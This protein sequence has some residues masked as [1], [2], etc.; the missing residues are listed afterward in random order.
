ML[1]LL[2]RLGNERYAL[3]ASQMV[4]VLPLLNIRIIPQSPPEIS[5]IIDYRGASMPVIDLSRLLLQRPASSKL[6][7]RILVTQYLDEQGATHL[8]G[9]I[10]EN[11]TGMTRREPSE[12]IPAGV[13]SSETPYLGPV[14]I[15]SACEI[16]QWI[17]VASLLPA[18]VRG[19][20]FRR[21]AEA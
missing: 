14:A 17:N 15:D 20:L 7:T 16:L 18:S 2:I 4:E 10:A 6:S 11:A 8:L 3:D 12:F 19:Q 5:G 1:F 21:L 9:L 13:S